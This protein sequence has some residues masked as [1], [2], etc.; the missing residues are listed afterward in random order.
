MITLRKIFDLGLEK[1]WPK[2]KQKREI[3]KEHPCFKNNLEM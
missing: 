1:I 3:N 2:E